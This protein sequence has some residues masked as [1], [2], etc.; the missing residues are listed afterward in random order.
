MLE[1]YDIKIFEHKQERETIRG[2]SYAQ[3]LPLRTVLARYNIDFKLFRRK[4]VTRIVR[5]GGKE[6]AVQNIRDMSQRE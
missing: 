6:N 4:T 1:T 2:L 3:M 5:E